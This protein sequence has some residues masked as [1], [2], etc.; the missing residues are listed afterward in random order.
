MTPAFLR[1]V[2][3]VFGADADAISYAWPPRSEE[4]QTEALRLDS[5]SRSIYAL[6]DRLEARGPSKSTITNEDTK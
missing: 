2:A 5:E 4:E 1:D 6:A 3:R